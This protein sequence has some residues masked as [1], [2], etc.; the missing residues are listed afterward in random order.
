MYYGQCG[1]GE[2][3]FPTISPREKNSC[4]RF[5]RYKRSMGLN[6]APSIFNEDIIFVKSG[7]LLCL[8]NER[9]YEG[10]NTVCFKFKKI[11]IDIPP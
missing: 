10:E 11:T 8:S 7:L 3:T 9:I 6:S 4:K 5:H 2:L 1:N